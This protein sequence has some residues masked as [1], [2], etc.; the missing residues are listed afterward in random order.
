[1]YAIDLAC[2]VP[3]RTTFSYCIKSEDIRRK[4]CSGQPST[5]SREAEGASV[6]SFSARLSPDNKSGTFF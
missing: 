2:E 3:L 1:M 6:G 4:R 5:V